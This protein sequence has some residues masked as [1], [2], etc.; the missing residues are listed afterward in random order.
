MFYKTSLA[1]SEV[2]FFNIPL[3]RVKINGNI[4]AL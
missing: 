3:G 1:N 4:C 2:H